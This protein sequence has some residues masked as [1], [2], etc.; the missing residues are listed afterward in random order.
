MSSDGTQ[1]YGVEYLLILQLSPIPYVLLNQLFPEKNIVDAT[2]VKV[3]QLA[4]SSPNKTES[5]MWNPTRIPSY[6]KHCS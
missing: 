5:G 3:S 2:V 1:N 6:W 4:E